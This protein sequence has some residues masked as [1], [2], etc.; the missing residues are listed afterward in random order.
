[1]LPALHHRILSGDFVFQV[2][3][4]SD[5]DV[6]FKRGKIERGDEKSNILLAL[7]EM[8]LV[9]I[10]KIS[11]FGFELTHSSDLASKDKF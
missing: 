7:F 11:N 8:V 1:M 3:K 2:Q 9:L 10:L 5:Q 6:V 4:P